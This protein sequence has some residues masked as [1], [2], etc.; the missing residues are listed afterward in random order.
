MDWMDGWTWRQK[1]L[2]AWYPLLIVKPWTCQQP[3]LEPYAEPADSHHACGPQA[4]A[5]DATIAPW[6]DVGPCWRWLHEITLIISLIY[7]TPNQH[8][9]V[10]LLFGQ[11]T[12]SLVLFGQRVQIIIA[13][14]TAH[15]SGLP[16]GNVEKSS[17][18]AVLLCCCQSDYFDPQLSTFL[19]IDVLSL[20]LSIDHCQILLTHYGQPWSSLFDDHEH[21]YWPLS[22]T[23]TWEPFQYFSNII[24]LRIIGL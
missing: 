10:I 1:I 4:T 7:F 23:I 18:T 19:K 21:N 2:V 14:R 3:W 8:L 13:G 16:P 22:T 6:E 15:P 5:G 20:S 17:G 11:D 24:I 9:I 12:L